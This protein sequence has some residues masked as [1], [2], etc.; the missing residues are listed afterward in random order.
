MSTVETTSVDERGELLAQR[1]LNSSLLHAQLRRVR[2]AMLTARALGVAD[3]S[4]VVPLYL[5]DFSHDDVWLLDAQHQAMAFDDMVI[6][7]QV[8]PPACVAV[9][10]LIVGR[11]AKRRQCRAVRSVRCAHRASEHRFERARA[12]QTMSRV[13]MFPVLVS[14]HHSRVRENDAKST[15]KRR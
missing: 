12:S 9:V 13:S 4:S 15:L 6:A 10:A 14:E 3:S 5:L 7:I 11:R 8:E 2:G 1:H